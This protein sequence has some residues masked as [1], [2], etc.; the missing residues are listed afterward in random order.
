[1]KGLAIEAKIFRQYLLPEGHFVS[2]Y[3]DSCL[4]REC[5]VA[6]LTKLEGEL[7]QETAGVN[8][9]PAGGNGTPISDI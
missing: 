1:L 3:D 8:G 7:A 5:T 2:G 9:T 6:L 4:I